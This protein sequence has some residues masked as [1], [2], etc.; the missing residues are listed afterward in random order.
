MSPSGG[1]DDH[2]RALHDVV[3]RE[4]HALLLRAGSRGGSRR[5]P[6]CAAAVRRNS[7]ASMTVAVAERAVESTL[8]R[9]SPRSERQDLGAGALLEARGAGR[10]VGVGV[11]EQ[12]PA[13]AVA[14]AAG[15]GVEVG[16]V[17]GPGVDDD[18]LVDAD[19]VGVGA[20]AGHHARVVGARCGAPWAT[21][22]RPRRRR[23]ASAPR[24]RCRRS[25][26]PPSSPPSVRTR[27][28]LPSSRRPRRRRDRRRG[29]GPPWR[30]SRRTGC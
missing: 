13:D 29:R 17:V 15:D 12:D 3:A 25:R 27:A 11:G 22:R 4:Q 6:A 2:G 18:D 24:R 20:R 26:P 1:R 28:G 16:V 14:A 9:P 10:V 8:P 21:A 30:G 23:A 19:Q 5:G 7:V